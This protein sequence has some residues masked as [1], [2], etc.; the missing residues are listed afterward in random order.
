MLDIPAM[1]IVIAAT[2]VVVGVVLAVLELRGAAKQRRT[3]I[4]MNL[5]TY[6]GTGEFTSALEKIR[7]RDPKDY[8]EYT[9][10]YGLRK[11][12]QVSSVFEGLGF[13]MHR[14]LVDKDLASLFSSGESLVTWEKIQSMVEGARK[15]LSQRKAGEYIPKLAWWQ[16]F[17]DEVKKREGKLQSLEG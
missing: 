8:R 16:Y 13:L 12:I 5:Y 3:A 7:A 4:L 9:E 11:L 15:D 2:S 10:E 14:K 1:S 17:Y 6:L